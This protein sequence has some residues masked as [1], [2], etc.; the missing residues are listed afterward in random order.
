[1]PHIFVSE[2]FWPWMGVWLHFT[3]MTLMK[4]TEVSREPEQ[5][6][7]GPFLVPLNG[8]CWVA[9]NQERVHCL[10]RLLALR[11]KGMLS[12]NVVLASLYHTSQAGLIATRILELLIFFLVWVDVGY[13]CNPFQSPRSL[14][15]S[16][17]SK[18]YEKN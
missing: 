15:V 11:R 14:H 18:G 12:L 4:A 16:T 7:C 17:Y 8:Y 9:S 10:W 5:A 6:T 3:F 1:M 13:Y 2:Q